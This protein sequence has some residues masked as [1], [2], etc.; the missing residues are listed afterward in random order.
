M[1]DKV[2]FLQDEEGK[3]IT[4][5]EHQGFFGPEEVLLDESGKVIAS[6]EVGAHVGVEIASTL[7]ISNLTQA[8]TQFHAGKVH[9]K[10][11]LPG[12]QNH[13]CIETYMLPNQVKTELRKISCIAH[14]A[15]ERCSI[16]LCPE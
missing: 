15:C 9:D 1:S 16:K 7:R 14:C 2:T 13:C 4:K 8:E 10:K 6:H 11:C 5:I 3:R 12:C